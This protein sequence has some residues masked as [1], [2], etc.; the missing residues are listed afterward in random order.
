MYSRG[1]L[2]GQH[3]VPCMDNPG[4]LTAEIRARQLAYG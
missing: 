2:G 3:K 1:K 4:R